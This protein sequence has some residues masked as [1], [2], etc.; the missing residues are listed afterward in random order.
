MAPDSLWLAHLCRFIYR[1]FIS[2][3]LSS[4]REKKNEKPPRTRVQVAPAAIV[5][6]G[7]DS[8]CRFA[9]P[10]KWDSSSR[11][12]ITFPHCRIG[13]AGKRWRAL[14]QESE[15]DGLGFNLWPHLASEPELRRNHRASTE[16]ISP[17]EFSF[18]RCRWLPARLGTSGSA[19][20]L[21]T[22]ALSQRCFLHLFLLFEVEGRSEG[23]RRFWL[24]NVHQ[25]WSINKTRTPH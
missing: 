11:L 25:R 20:V 13:V 8:V 14:K 12:F 5:C 9:G 15:S 17:A 1:I 21:F 4:R 16:L 2:V 6:T 10:I 23:L 18:Q 19:A 3:R 22:A 24:L 7:Y